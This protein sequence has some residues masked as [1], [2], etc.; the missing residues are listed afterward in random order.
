MFICK[1]C[2]AFEKNNINYAIVGGYAVALHGAIRGTLD[3]DYIIAWNKKEL[4]S[5]VN[6]LNE[7]GLES[8]IPVTAEQI[9]ENRDAYVKEKNMIAW[10]FA[11]LKNPLEQVDLLIYYDL[12]NHLVDIIKTPSCSIRILNKQDL[13]TMKQKSGRP[14]DL[15]DI[16]ALQ[17]L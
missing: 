13:I 4:L 15:E 9:F 7:L 5:A 2:Q 3:I 1:V 10:H 16:K 12:S 11:N 6:V 14:Q 8:R 17:L